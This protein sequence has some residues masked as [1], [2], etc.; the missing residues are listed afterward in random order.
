MF[1]GRCVLMSR[2]DEDRSGPHDRCLTPERGL[3][4]KA[5]R[6]SLKRVAGFWLGLLAIALV[7][8]LLSPSGASA[9]ILWPPVRCFAAATNPTIG[10]ATT[11]L[12][13]RELRTRGYYR[14]TECL[15]SPPV[16]GQEY[17]RITYCGGPNGGGVEATE[18][19][20]VLAHLGSVA[21][22]VSP[23]VQWEV[24]SYDLNGT[25]RRAD[26]TYDPN[27]QTPGAGP[28][29]QLYEL[30]QFNP[31][32]PTFSGA[33]TQA[34]G[35]IANLTAGQMQPPPVEG[36]VLQG[37]FDAF[38]TPAGGDCVAPDGAHV[39]MFNV[40]LSWQPRPGVWGIWSYLAPC[41]DPQT[42]PT[43]KPTSTPDAVPVLDSWPNSF[44]DG[45]P[46]PVPGTKIPVIPPGGQPTQPFDPLP[47][48]IPISIPTDPPAGAP[49]DTPV[50][51][52]VAD[53]APLEQAAED[54]SLACGVDEIECVE[55]GACVVAPEVC[56]GV[57]GG[58]AAASLLASLIAGAFGDPHL[59]TFDGLAYDLQSAGEFALASD[60][61]VGMDVQGRF[62]PLGSSST[63]SVATAAAFTL[64]SHKVEIGTGGQDYLKINGTAVDLAVGKMMTFGD[65]A[66]LM[67]LGSEQY[68]AVWPG[69]G[70]RPALWTAPNSIKIY[71]PRGAQTSGLYGG[72]P[73]GNP[74]NDLV[75]SAG[76]QLPANADA[77]TLEG[78][79][80]DSWRISP[81]E[82][83][84]TYA[85]GQDT[86]TF[87]DPTFP[88]SVLTIHDLAASAVTAGT[89]QCSA[90]AVS[91]GPQFDDCVV[92]WAQS[93]DTNLVASAA[94]QTAPLILGG[95]STVDA[96][97]VETEDFEG[98][99]APNYVAAR[100]G[101][102][103]GT[104]T[105]AGPFGPGDR[106]TFSAPQLPSHDS[107]TISFD[108]VTLGAW[109]FNAPNT[110][111]TVDI[112]GQAAGTVT[113]DSATPSSTGTTPDGQS[114]A[115]YP[116]TVTAPDSQTQ[117]NVGVH[118]DLQIGSGAAFGVDNVRVALHLIPPQEFDVSL[119]AS[120]SNG[121]PSA[122]A[123][124]L[125]TTASED[126]YNFS[127]ATAGTVVVDFNQ[128]DCPNYS[129]NWKLVDTSSGSTI[130]SSGSCGHFEIPNVP[131]GSY[132]LQVT[133][134]G[135]TGTYDGSIQL[136]PPPEQF[137]V[138]LPA[139][140][141]NGQPSAGAGNLET[142]ASQDDYNF[143][144][145]TDGTVVV[146]FN[147]YDCPNYSLDWALVD[148]SSGSS[149][150]SSGSCGQS[151]IAN[152]P[153]GSYSLQVTKPGSTGSYDGN[154]SL[155]PVPTAASVSPSFGDAGASN[156]SV[157]ITGSAFES[158]AAVSFS[159]SG[160][161]VNSTTFNSATSLTA[162]ITISPSAASGVSDVT[163]ANPDGGIGT[164]LGGFVVSGS[165][166]VGSA[167]PGSLDQGARSQT[168]A[169]NGANFENGAGIS[170]SGTGITV[171]SV[172]FVTSTLLAA[173]VSVDTAAATGARDVTVTNPDNSSVVG[174]GVFRVA[175]APTV[176]SL[177]PGSVGQGASGQ[178]VTITGSGFES[179]AAVSFSGSGVTVNSTTFNSA[180][181]LTANVSVSASAATG[182]RNLTVT[183][184]DNS[185]AAS[186]GALTIN[187]GPTVTA[188]SPSALATGASSQNV[189]ITG[190][191]FRT[192]AAVSFSGSGITVN[193][194]TFNSATSLTANVTVG[195]GAATG[196]RN[197]T[198]T[199]PDAGTGSCSSAFTVDAL[200]AV[201]G[202]SPSSGE[203]GA[204]NYSV[205]ITGT[206]F[207]SGAAV[208]FS[209][210]GITINSTTFNS[211]T[212]LT[213][214]ISISA[215]AAT[216]ARNITVTNG[217][218]GAGTATSV[219]TVAAAPTVGSLSPG[220]VG[221]GASGQNVTITGSG[222]ESGAAVSFSGSG[223]TV[224]STTFNSASS[225]TANVS[226]SASAATGARNLTVTNPDNSSA[227]S[228]GALTINA[229]PTVT[230]ASPSALATGA[231][232]QNV[233]ITGT[234]FR[235]GA[236][237]SF[238]GSGITVNSTTFNSAT[239]LTAN[240]TVGAG[241]ATGS[242]NIT[243]TNP[244]AGTGSCSAC[245]S[246][247]GFAKTAFASAT[248][249][250]SLTSTSFTIAAG[251]SYL[252]FG[253]S[254]S[255]SG[256][257][258]TISSTGFSTAPTATA[259]A[260][261]DYNGRTVHSWAWYLTGGS[262]SG[263]IKITLSKTTSQAYLQV[264][265]VT[266]ANTTTPISTSNEGFSVSGG[267]APSTTTSA[268]ATATLPSSPAAGDAEI[269]FWSSDSKNGT[270]APSSSS[271][272]IGPV[273][274]TFSAAT[275]GS[276]AV[277][278][279]GGTSSTLSL[280]LSGSQ[281]W[282]TIA[283]EIKHS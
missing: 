259:V 18:Q 102:G 147:V 158:G 148:T 184:P 150:Y 279:G 37:W 234:G 219:F 91:D 247:Y 254:K 255:S 144:T 122:G 101:T 3:L 155:V 118:S 138:S 196:S 42:Q 62:E 69:Q 198:A 13:G 202:A 268:T 88:S 170:F 269:I 123:G 270:S 241:A 169:I 81:E 110:S 136:K 112:N 151:D 163:V 39:N 30:K 75:T 162:N 227:A 273:S 27:N 225:L 51:D 132:Q 17:P 20:R 224:N 84:F 126:D 33:A 167:S 281:H 251:T 54:V 137:A 223:V 58:S 28:P 217:D 124:N 64:D 250:T 230:A 153:A 24:M 120:F 141:S 203:A 188:A 44:W 258:A 60:D 171:N 271:A 276:E 72:P 256:D 265:S 117:L 74:S 176:G 205:A 95:S 83:L 59:R 180:S 229:G 143:S 201:T 121:Q 191:G 45:S 96:S 116:V 245:L 172:S 55:V 244:D 52:P 134:P 41:F 218:T 9:G 214:N 79:Y 12:N 226:V 260:Q 190:T 65:G 71:M 108:L 22:G 89:Q 212:S 232:S 15:S 10:R 48:P 14:S 57:D 237:V 80:A 278:A 228:S 283:L 239:S 8:S 130:Q 94:A 135:S 149:V 207:V 85:P 197:I 32:D 49:T 68:F 47:I 209:G 194:T 97:G 53:L 98:S 139:S 111:V 266:G 35:Y 114:Y 181:S 40:Y 11:C 56:A 23:D 76:E 6:S 140:F 87:T 86:T 115:V 175:A 61:A 129:L 159:G 182:A 63:V 236:A 174:S 38:E 78:T 34:D 178:N 92:D 36:A 257:S 262:G 127:T 183:N 187:A 204:S 246:I 146:D 267:S 160:I 200:P 165:P 105:F 128:Y 220:S 264:I 282:G 93:Q 154:I 213:A 192:G 67:H 243:A 133:K 70:D 233:T 249:G 253:S 107:A 106:Y 275:N 152:V 211:A 189:T 177:S 240:V 195:A 125:E 208:S 77:T 26:V 199:N 193:S 113:F 100:Y 19:A 21:G 248:T 186:S 185:S 4:Q 142:T 210:S 206:G 168:I 99:V 82:S 222:F 16:V 2:T 231:S 179:G 156:Y 161:T 46:Q 216:G 109:S 166:V 145:S 43:P 73:D 90:A 221:Q 272:W 274:G 5:Q 173:N 50:E 119:P 280:G 1:A 104:G 25:R 131:A 7:L 277:Y 164:E 29:V 263:T 66:S 238:S 103:A 31:Q 242:R 157:G 215:G 261:Q 235:T 252:V